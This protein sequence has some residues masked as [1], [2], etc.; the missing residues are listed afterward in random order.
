MKR[1]LI[2]ILIILALTPGLVVG[3]GEKQSTAELIT[4]LATEEPII[5]RH[6]ETLDTISKAMEAITLEA[7]KPATPKDEPSASSKTQLEAIEPPK[8][9]T[10]VPVSMYQLSTEEIIKA[11]TTPAPKSEPTIPSGLKEALTS[12]VDTL[13]WALERMDSEIFDYKRLSPPPEARTYHGLTVEIL[14]KERAIYN[15]FRSYY[16]S[17]LSYGYGDDEALDRAKK[18]SVERQR[19]WLLAQYELDDLIQRI[20]Q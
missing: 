8:P 14:L 16:R 9:A 20:E 15:D 3:C 4:F 12:G 6:N 17:L 13:D 11:L 19:L 1:Y 5:K 2:L 18:Q 7:K 10:N